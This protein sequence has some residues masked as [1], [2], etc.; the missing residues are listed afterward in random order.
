MKERNLIFLVNSV[1]LR[2]AHVTRKVIVDVKRIEKYELSAIPESLPL[3][4]K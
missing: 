1:T 4:K 2:E 3:S